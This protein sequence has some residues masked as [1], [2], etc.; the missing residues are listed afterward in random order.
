MRCLEMAHVPEKSIG[1]P[2][3]SGE[4][5]QALPAG[6][7]SRNQEVVIGFC[8]TAHTT[9]LFRGVT[10]PSGGGVSWS[11]SSANTQQ[12]IYHNPPP[13]TAPPENEGATGRVVIQ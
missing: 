12:C 5:Q 3:S 1:H 10:V 13:H 6:R 11:I 2:R 7:L 4:W 8:T 9:E